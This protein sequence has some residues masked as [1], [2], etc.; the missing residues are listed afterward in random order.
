[1]EYK[2]DRGA[3]IP[4]RVRSL[5][6]SAQHDKNVTLEQLRQDLMEKVV[7]VVIPEKYLD[8][9][10]EYHIQPSGKFIIGGPQVCLNHCFNSFQVS[11][12]ILIFDMF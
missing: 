3:C 10:T 5:V 8:N 7:K 9:E 12:I 2:Y 4:L 6:I 11:H 1:M